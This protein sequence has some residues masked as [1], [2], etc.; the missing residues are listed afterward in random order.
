[1]EDNKIQLV[2]DAVTIFGKTFQLPKPIILST[3]QYASVR[4]T[5]NKVTISVTKGKPAPG[6]AMCLRVTS[7]G[8][9]YVSI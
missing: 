7:M 8:I 4:Q 9:E 3:G 6:Y 5:G 1:M 2:F